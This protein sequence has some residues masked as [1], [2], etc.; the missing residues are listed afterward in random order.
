MKQYSVHISIRLQDAPGGSLITWLHIRNWVLWLLDHPKRDSRNSSIKRDEDSETG[1]SGDRI[2][3]H[4]AVVSDMWHWSAGVGDAAREEWDSFA[5][6]KTGDKEDTQNSALLIQEDGDEESHCSICLVEEGT[7][8]CRLPCSYFYPVP[9]FAHHGINSISVLIDFLFDHC[10]MWL[11][12]C[13]LVHEH[14]GYY[15]TQTKAHYLSI[16]AS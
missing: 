9:H 7:K 11:L 14:H 10:S 4:E 5:N 3:D 6:T 1:Q 12:N 15:L 2:T 16:E 13:C 8:L